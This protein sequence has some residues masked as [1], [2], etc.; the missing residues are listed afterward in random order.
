MRTRI[1][2]I[3]RGEV[4]APGEGRPVE[5]AGWVRSRRDSKGGF[6]FL[7][8]ADGST[9]AGLQ[10]VVDARLPNYASEVLHLGTGAAVAVRGRLVASQGRGQR[11]EVQAETVTVHGGCDP[12]AYPLQKQATSMEH[13]RGIPH[14]R[15]RTR[16][17]Q[18][19]M[20]VRAAASHAIHDFFRGRGFLYLHTPIITAADCEGAGEQFRVTTLP[21]DDPP[22]GAD[23][24]VDATRDFF[25]RPAYLTVSGQLEGETYACAMGDIYTFG[26]T[27]RAEPSTTPRHLAEFWMVEPEMSFCDLAGDV[28]LAID[29]VRAVLRS[30]LDGCDAELE[31][32]ERHQAPG[33]RAE[34]ARLAGADVAR[35]TYAEAIAVLG[36]SGQR[37]DH[38]VGWGHDLQTEHERFL[39]ERHCRGP[40]VITDYPQEIKAFYMR[41]NDDGRSVAAMDLL[42]PR[43][44]ELIGGS[45]REERLEVLL[46]RLRGA[47][48]DPAA[49][50]PYLDL[51]RFGSVPHAGFGLGFERLVCLLTGTANI[52]D[53]IPFPRTPGHCP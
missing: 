35:L 53:V 39:V 21:A 32:L 12:A 48:L 40:V 18:A 11:V 16:S 23:G 34:L 36:R 29:F 14:L 15:A 13:L 9:V 41:L 20:R 37:F 17:V 24:R 47:G 42:V 2:E 19:I 31:L 5:V 43:M 52:R 26:P 45:Q 50:G 10:I 28:A 44:G 38:P 3:L 30:V 49:F 7:D 8:L 33:L 25:G 46:G 1:A 6:S 4:P 22:R 27:F 51:R